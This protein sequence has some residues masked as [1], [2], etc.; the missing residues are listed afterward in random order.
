M[1]TFSDIESTYRTDHMVGQILERLEP[2]SDIFWNW[3][4]A[5]FTSNIDRPELHVESLKAEFDELLSDFKAEIVALILRQSISPDDGAGMLTAFKHAH[6]IGRR[7]LD[8]LGQYQPGT[9]SK[10]YGH[11][12]AVTEAM[13]LLAA[14]FEDALIQG[15]IHSLRL[16][17]P[18][19]SPQEASSGRSKNQN[20][21]EYFK[22][23]Q[24]DRKDW[25]EQYREHGQNPYGSLAYQRA[26]FRET[27]GFGPEDGMG[28]EEAT[29]IS[30]VTR[31]A[32]YESM[33]WPWR[34]IVFSP[35]HE[36]A[37]ETPDHLPGVFRNGS[38][39]LS[40]GFIVPRTF[41]FSSPEMVTWE[42]ARGQ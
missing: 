33:G 17:E 24:A 38:P 16:G 6:K 30:S 13:S 12:L 11:T 2:L 42:W 22:N 9:E 27:R 29:S 8:E 7:A 21:N 39:T 26:A 15:L 37:G 5:S 19:S 34:D 28:K 23:F 36:E 35:S 32:F 4:P 18:D 20:V 40:V 14:Y 41:A 25:C 3:L 1:D 10:R 31:V